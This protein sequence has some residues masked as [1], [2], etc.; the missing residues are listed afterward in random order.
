MEIEKVKIDVE[1]L[2]VGMY[3]DSLDRPWIETPFLFQGFPV[4]NQDDIDE[5]KNYCKF[6]YIDVEKG[7]PPKL[8]RRTVVVAQ[9]A[10]AVEVDSGINK[11]IS[12]RN[13]LT[14][15]PEIH[16]EETA[17]LAEEM[18]AAKEVQG[19][20]WKSIESITEDI[21]NGKHPDLPMVK[22]AIKPM[23]ESVLR[24]PDA[25]MWL[26]ML[27]A[28]DEY[29]Y[30][31]T[32]SA[33][34]LATNFG[35][36]LGL[37]KKELQNLAMGA[38]LFDIGKNKI[39]DNLLKKPSRLTSKEFEYVKKHVEIG[40]KLLTNSEGI[41]KEIIHMVYCHHERHDGS[42]YP[43]GLLGDAIPPYG[44]IASIVDCYDAI[45]SKRPYAEPLT[46]HEATS[47]LYEWRN[48]AFQAEL[49]EQFIQSIGIF[50][51]GTLVELTTGQVGAVIAQNKTRR[52]RPRVMIILD[53]NKA[54]YGNFPIIDL[55]SETE[56][57]DGNSLEIVHGLEANAYGIDPN[58]FYL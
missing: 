53:E 32:L 58:D 8:E 54:P 23:V 16:Y 31:H 44:K 22:Q 17:S 37:P 42:G 50:P 11:S 3:V 34:V 51:T 26:A 1:D 14:Q 12:L 5:L 19:A 35:R 9:K 15:H 49:V 20:I 36:T 6:V 43:R 40:V 18:G 38:M 4:N 2:Q 33:S 29:S 45:I 39:P 57:K 55:V 47:K 24:N 10:S 13:S 27:K 21:R 46:P 28:K 7:L 30:N 56:D 25:F 48:H 52:L 41:T